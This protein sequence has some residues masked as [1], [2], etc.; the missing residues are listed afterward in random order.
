MSVTLRAVSVEN[1]RG[2]RSARLDL[3]RDVTILVG[4]NNAGKT[5]LLRLLEW[6]LNDADEEL[7]R[8]ERE[9][10]DEEVAL[11]IPARNTRGGARRLN[12]YAHVWDGRR[13]ERFRADNGVS[14]IRF[15]VRNNRVFLN[16]RPPQQS[17]P[18]GYE[19]NAVILLNELR[20][21]I[22][23]K[24]I[25]SSRDAAS[26]RF[27]GTLVDAIEAKLRERAVHRSRAGAPGEYRQITE[28][29]ETLRAV[30][31]RLTQPLWDQMS[32]SV[33]PGLARSG[34][35]SLKLDAAHLVEWMSTQIAFSLVTGEHDPRAVP[36][37]E[38]GSGL[39]SLI[40]LAVL[41]TEH[42]DDEVTDILAIEEPEA[43]L[44]PSAQR[45]LARELLKSSESTKLIVSTHSP[46]FVDE[47]EYGAV[48]LVRNHTVFHPQDLS[49]IERDAINTALL[50]GQ[51]S[52]AIF[53]TSVLFVEGEG[54]KAYFEALRRRVAEVD[55]SGRTDEMA[56]VS[57]GSKSS[58]AP[59]IQLVESYRDAVTGERPISWLVVADGADA[60]RD[61]RTAF[62]RAGLTIPI[63]V[64]RALREANRRQASSDQQER[65]DSTRLVN[66]LAEEAGVRF[67]LLPID[68]EWCMFQSLTA[69]TV[70]SVATQCGFP[71]MDRVAL[72]RKLGSK[73]GEG[74]SASP[75][76]DRWIRTA[77]GQS[78][79]WRE[80]SPDARAVLRRWLLGTRLEQ[81]AVD[82]LL[83]RTGASY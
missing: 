16:V 37:I 72:L 38:V 57:V 79:T 36:P 49:D 54:D 59:W 20:E 53:A 55:M 63:E 68:L 14:R 70:S 24:F 46:V 73:Y 74:P 28:A 7:V 60:G 66:Q 15:R 76:K 33:L 23:Y 44:H 12:L 77:V 65:I 8:G 39:Q 3:S 45:R 5:S 47:A 58:F 56:I 6:A 17:E 42:G 9:L 48:V 62:S 10:S 13:H 52:E 40:D 30:A 83:R 75:R 78:V 11:L 27:Q 35:F 25:P 61:V 1:L 64:E 34:Y 29:L 50:A 67:H 82:S 22:F 31:E 71:D 43:F 4:P 19:E 21:R 18:L 32:E 26:D 51:G 41:R 81:K 80:V 69:E 2:F